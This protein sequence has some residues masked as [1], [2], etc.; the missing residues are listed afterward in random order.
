[1]REDGFGFDKLVLALSSSYTPTGLGPTESVAALPAIIVIQSANSSV[2]TWSSGT[3]QS[4][5]S[6]NGPYADV[7]G[8]ANPYTLSLSGPAQFYRLRQ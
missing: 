4:S 1:M 2:L 8:A 3:L 6:V 7:P 5:A